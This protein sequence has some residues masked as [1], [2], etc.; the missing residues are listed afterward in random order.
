M[1]MKYNPDTGVPY[2]LPDLGEEL[3]EGVTPKPTVITSKS[4]VFKGDKPLT[5]EEYEFLRDKGRVEP[6]KERSPFGK[7]YDEVIEPKK[8]LTKEQYEALM[9]DQPRPDIEKAD[10]MLADAV[11]K[12]TQAKLDKDM[13]TDEEV[14]EIERLA[15]SHTILHWPTLLRLINRL[16]RAEGR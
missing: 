13:A 4:D 14:D 11:A 6:K 9:G 7:F 3:E 10:E 1:P 12:A 16:R 2:Y 5:K 15:S 8:P